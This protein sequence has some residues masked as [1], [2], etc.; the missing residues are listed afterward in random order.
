MAELGGPLAHQLPLHNHRGGLVQPSLVMNHHLEMDCHVGGGVGGGTG[1]EL[2][3][4]EYINRYRRH[5]NVSC[6]MLITI[7]ANQL[8]RQRRR[9]FVVRKL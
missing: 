9:Q 2:H 4:S 3:P 5:D 7:I 6:V 1:I 8:H